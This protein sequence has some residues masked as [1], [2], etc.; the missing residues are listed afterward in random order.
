MVKAL[1]KKK[2]QVT[3]QQQEALY[4]HAAK[5]NSFNERFKATPKSTLPPQ[6]KTRR[7]HRTSKFTRGER[8]GLKGSTPSR[9][10]ATACQLCRPIHHCRWWAGKNSRMPLHSNNSHSSA[11]STTLF[12]EPVPP[13]ASSRQWATTHTHK[14]TIT[15]KKK[16]KEGGGGGESES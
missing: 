10:L 2:R 11:C 8:T 15:Q 13:R 3:R 4:Q 6:R 9:L 14:H 12:L 16:K 7:G 1:K 5:I